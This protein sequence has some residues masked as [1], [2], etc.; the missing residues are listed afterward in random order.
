LWER[1]LAAE[2]VTCQRLGS[3]LRFRDHEGLAHELQLDDGA[4]AVD[5]VVVA[6]PHTAA[7]KLLPG[8]V[9]AAAL[10]ALGTSPIVNLH[11]HYDRRVLDEPFA[12]GVGTPVQFVFDRTA[13]S[14]V[15]AGQLIAVSLSGADAEIGEPVATLRERYLPALERLLPAARGATVRDFTDTR[16][17]R[18]TFRAAPGHGRLRPGTRTAAPGVYLAG[19]WTDTG[20]PATMESAV[21]S[22]HAAADAALDD[23]AG[24][25]IGTAELAGG[26]AA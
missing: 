26:K 22:G 3:V 21:L 8:L 2:R 10:E 18:A 12:A 16:E 23:L 19:A 1:R 6:V 24:G 17:P 20:W 25:R 7:A 14:G 11:V 5:A 4:D 9:D 15:T 13:S